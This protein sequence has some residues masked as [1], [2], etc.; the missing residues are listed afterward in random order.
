M[1]KKAKDKLSVEDVFQSRLDLGDDRFL[2]RF[3]L[4]DKRRKFLFI[5]DQKESHL[6]MIDPI[7]QIVSDQSDQFLTGEII[8]DLLRHFLQSSRFLQHQK[9]SNFRKI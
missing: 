5:L 7:F 8:V 2:G 9:L 3:L 4:V 6:Q 1:E